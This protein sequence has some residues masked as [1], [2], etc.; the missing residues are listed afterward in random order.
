VIALHIEIVFTHEIGL[1]DLKSMIED[2]GATF[3]TTV[4]EDLTHLVT[5]EKDVE[6][7]TT[8][9]EQAKNDDIVTIFLTNKLDTQASA[10]PNC[11][12]VSLAWLTESAEAKKPLP[13]KQFVLGQALPSPQ[14]EIKKSGNGSEKKTET[15]KRSVKDEPAEEPNKKL[16]DIQK[17]SSKSLNVPVDE[18]FDDRSV[19]F[20]RESRW[21]HVM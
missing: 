7:Q 21:N 10:I 3:S 5:T 2:N 18:G 4:T 14:P 16:K 1:A 15:K 20:V 8:K 12:I 19:G 13:E 6:K 17:A 9:C 11:K